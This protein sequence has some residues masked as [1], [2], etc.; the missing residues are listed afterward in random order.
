MDIIER[1]RTRGSHNH[2]FYLP[3]SNINGIVE[4][5]TTVEARSYLTIVTLGLACT[6]ILTSRFRG[7]LLF[8]KIPLLMLLAIL[9]ESSQMRIKPLQESFVE[10]DGTDKVYFA[11]NYDWPF[12]FAF[13]KRRLTRACGDDDNNN[14]TPCMYYPAVYIRIPTLL[15]SCANLVV[16]RQGTGKSPGVIGY[17]Q[18][19]RCGRD[20]KRLRFRQK[21][22]LHGISVSRGTN[23]SRLLERE[24]DLSSAFRPPTEV[25]HCF[26]YFQNDVYNPIRYQEVGRVT[27][28]TKCIV[29]EINLRILTERHARSKTP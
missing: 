6:F 17:G 1:V 3:R 22:L 2:P 11:G 23:D 14:Y 19:Q 7:R 24:A 15:L 13:I 10:S 25:L 26:Y 8:M 18:Q 4:S 28:A 20:V 12:R 5:A 27:R 29:E 9:R 21:P 16:S